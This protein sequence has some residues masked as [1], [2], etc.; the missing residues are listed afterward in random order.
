MLDEDARTSRMLPGSEL[1]RA[2]P[3]AHGPVCSS[4]ADGGRP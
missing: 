1:D 4:V 3:L 2:P